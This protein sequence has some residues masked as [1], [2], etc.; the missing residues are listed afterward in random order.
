MSTETPH[1]SA[2]FPETSS[3]GAPG[4]GSRALA[5]VVLAGLF[6]GFSLARSP[7]PGVNESHYLSKA[8]HFW[9]PEWCRGDLFLES[10]NPHAVFYSVF[11]WMTTR[12]TMDQVALTIRCFQSLLLAIGWMAL[13][14]RSLGDQRRAIFAAVVF[15]LLHA[16]GSWSGEWLVGGAESKVWSYGFLMLGMAWAVDGRWPLAGLMGGLAISFHPV[17][18][19]WGVV[20]AGLAWAMH[21]MIRPSSLAEG[22]TVPGLVSQRFGPLVLACSLALVAALPGLIPAIQSLKAPSPE[23]ASEADFLQVAERLPHHLDP[24]TFPV[25]AWRDYA[26][27]LLVWG[28]V[29]SRIRNRGPG[30]I[31]MELAMWAA[32]LVALGGVL[33]AWGPRPIKQMPLWEL[34][35]KLMKLYPFRL[36]DMLIPITVAMAVSAAVWDRVELLHS[37]RQRTGL[38]AIGTMLFLLLAFRVPGMDR[39]LGQ[40]PEAY[41]RDWLAACT[42]IREQTPLDAN[43]YATNDNWSLRWYTERPEYFHFKDCPQDAASIVEWHRRYWVIYQ[44]KVQAF[45]DGRVSAEELSELRKNTGITHLICGRFGPLEIAPVFTSANVKVY[46]LPK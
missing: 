23:V 19:C 40:Q 33:A 20:I 34:R 39:S 29:R 1:P 28:L 46:E 15:L 5:V 45:L 25:R 26:L 42:W 22:A 30:L 36:V 4:I 35:V 31:W 8:R 18:G 27:L 10:A 12:M 14:V 17:V 38:M 41:Q 7:I 32:L 13:A 9:Q 37:A 2:P 21:R 11:G 24:L 3:A 43:L 6:L 16:T 44:W